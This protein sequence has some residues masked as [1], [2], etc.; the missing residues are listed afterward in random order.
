MAIP[1]IDLDTCT[2]CGDCAEQCPANAVEVISGRGVI[3][4]AEECNYCT[5]CETFCPSGAIRC[6]LEIIL[7]KA[8]TPEKQ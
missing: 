3:V 8:E 6:P 7:V 4:R 5:D 1:E 2:E